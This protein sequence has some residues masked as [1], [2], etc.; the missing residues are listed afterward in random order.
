MLHFVCYVIL[1]GAPTNTQFC[2]VSRQFYLTLSV[3]RCRSN[4]NIYACLGRPI[5]SL[6]GFC[7]CFS[8]SSRFWFPSCFQLVIFFLCFLPFIFLMQISLFYFLSLI[9]VSHCILDLNFNFTLYETCMHN[10]SK[11]LNFLEN[12]KSFLMHEY[13]WNVMNFLKNLMN[14][15]FK[16]IIFFKICQRL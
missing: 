11:T 12:I 13:F 5:P 15:V 9:Y 6:A 2:V 10:F 16:F 3:S 1:L 14:F 8:S 4:T 7:V